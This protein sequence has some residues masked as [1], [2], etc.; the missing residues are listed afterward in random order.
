VIREQSPRGAWREVQL[1][2]LAACKK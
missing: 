1:L 2:D